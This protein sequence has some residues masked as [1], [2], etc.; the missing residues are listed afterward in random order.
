MNYEMLFAEHRDKR[1]SA[2]LIG[3]GEFGASLIAQSRSIAMLELRVLCD[4]DAARALAALQQSGIA[5]DDIAVC[6][7]ADLALGALDKGKI[8][9]ITDAA[10]IDQMPVDIVVE[11]T[12][13]PEV[14]AQNARAAIDRGRHVAIVSKEADSVVGPIL[15]HLATEAGCVYTPIDGDQPSLLI[16]LI[17]WARVLGLEIVAA[18]KSSEYDFVYD[19]AAQTVSWRDQTIEVPGFAELWDLPDDDVAAVLKQRRAALAAFPQRIVPD[20]CEMGIVSNATG[21]KPD[22]DIFHAPHARTIEVPGILR[23]REFGGVLGASGVLAASGIIDVFNCLR[24][25]DEASFAGGVFIVV[26][27]HDEATWTVLQSKGIPM[28]R[29][30]DHAL[31][32]NP[33]HL[34]G[35][36]APISIL[37]A[38]LLGHSTGGSAPKPIV[39]LVARASRDLKTGET[40]E[41]IDAHTHA[42]DGVDPLLVDASPASGNNPLPYY[43]ALG[44]RLGRDVPAGALLT[45][46]TVEIAD[47]S[48][49][50][51][52]RRLQ[53]ALFFDASY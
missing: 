19:P 6:D 37:S 39:D 48:T 11:A 10:L 14:A 41:I 27:C 53:D 52:L 12:G 38:A 29:Q 51:Q 22:L 45:A 26:R 5:A 21:L 3:V 1:V 43:L 4:R 15:H 28:S 40:L 25:P 32:Y 9:V 36:E 33:Q 13:V 50:R 47:D 7:N 34:L 24:R 23:P 2:A 31:L 46:D 35:I 17:S 18:G 49:L 20:Y 16:G 44:G 42:M 30:G 8:V